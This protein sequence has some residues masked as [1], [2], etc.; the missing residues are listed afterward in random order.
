MRFCHT[1]IRM[2][3]LYARLWAMCSNRTV[4]RVPHAIVTNLQKYRRDLR[5]WLLWLWYAS[6]PLGGMST[7]LW[8][9]GKCLPDYT[10]SRATRR[11]S[12][13]EKT[14]LFFS[15]CAVPLVGGL[16]IARAQCLAAHAASWLT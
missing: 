4:L 9:V 14:A 16:E 10:E 8:D 11:L 5:W 7:F 3:T 6:N 13:K 12:S 1:Q 15:V 2:K